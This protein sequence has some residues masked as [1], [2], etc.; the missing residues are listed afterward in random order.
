MKSVPEGHGFFRSFGYTIYFT[1]SDLFDLEKADDWYKKAAVQGSGNACLILGHIYSVD[2][3]LGANPL[4]AFA[5]YVEAYNK[6]VEEAAQAA[7]E[8]TQ[9]YKS[10][11]F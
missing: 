11:K 8:L 10:I 4:V 6:G 3:G 7:Y 9:R 2:I 5:W 1:D